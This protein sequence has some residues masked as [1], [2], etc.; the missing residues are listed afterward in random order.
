MIHTTK[1]YK[2]DQLI[3]LK[4]KFFKKVDSQVYQ[5]KKPDSK[6]IDIL[7]EEKATGEISAGAG[8]GTDGGTLAFAVKENNYLGKGIALEANA[9]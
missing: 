2:Q 8:A 5:G 4:D 1:F 6:I 7:V 9:T 3:I